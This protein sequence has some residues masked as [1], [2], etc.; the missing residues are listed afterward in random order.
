VPGGPLNSKTWVD[1]R[2]F[3]DLDPAAF[4]RH[5]ERGILAHS[6]TLPL[7]VLRAVLEC[8]A[9]A[10]DTTRRQEHHLRDTLAALR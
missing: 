8:V 5:S 1:L 3:D 9:A 10:D 7:T 2:P 6:H 4:H